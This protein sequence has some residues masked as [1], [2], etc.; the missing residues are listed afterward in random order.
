MPSPYSLTKQHPYWVMVGLVEG[1]VVVR[2]QE[3]KKG[4]NSSLCL[5]RWQG[6]KRA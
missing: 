2:W 3:Y 1:G 4:R 5:G 6:V